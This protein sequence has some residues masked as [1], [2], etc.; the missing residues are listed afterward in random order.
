M[1]ARIAD[2]AHVRPPV[3]HARGCAASST[4]AAGCRRWLDVL[5]A[6]ARAQAATG[7]IPAEAAEQIAAHARADLL[8]LDLVGRADPAHRALDARA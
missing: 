6:L 5:A 2:S 8:D 3:G 4:S 7:I 1:S